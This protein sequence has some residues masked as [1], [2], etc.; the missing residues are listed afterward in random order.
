M[1]RK[2]K[3]KYENII[4]LINNKNYLK[5]T[6]KIYLKLE[7]I[8]NSKKQKDIIDKAELAGLLINI[9][10]EGLIKEVVEEGL[11]IIESN[12]D[13]FVK[14]ISKNS[15][16]YN[17]GNA[18]K[19]I[20]DISRRKKNFQF[21]L[22]NIKILVEAKNHY[23]KSLKLFESSKRDDNE[24]RLKLLTN[25]GST[26][27]INCRIS[28]SLY[29]FDQVLK[30][31]PIFPQANVNRSNEL[32]WLKTITGRY[33][34]QLMKQAYFGYLKAYNSS[35]TLQWRKKELQARLEGIKQFIKENGYNVEDINDDKHTLREFNQ[36][37]EY[38]QYCINNRLTLN[39]H[40][41]YCKC[42][43][44]RNDDLSIASNNIIVGGK[45]FLQ[46][47]RL[48][49]RIKSEFVFARHLYYKS[50]I[51]MENESLQVDN[52]VCYTEL[53]D[54]EYIGLNSEMIRTSFRLCFGILDKIAEGLCKFFEL[55]DEK[56]NI[57]FDNF[58]NPK[59]LNTEKLQER[60][61]KLNSI[62][63]FSLIALYSQATD[64]NSKIGEWKIYKDWRNA[65]EHNMFI[66]I[67]S[68]EIFAEK[69]PIKNIP[70]NLIISH[71]DFTEKTFSMLQFV[72]SAIFNFAFCIRK[73]SL[74]ENDTKGLIKT[75]YPKNYLDNE[76]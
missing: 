34:I 13:V 49:N 14:Y 50:T 72:R 16:E 3:K 33:S 76:N 40:A 25:L 69:K 7:K 56:E 23:W 4:E 53:S 65:L 55:S 54:N 51:K 52:E 30:I 60:W 68:N 32:I 59:N 21:N 19:A 15:L 27:S 22:E 70:D 38:R 8:N 71:N 44:S 26:L 6:K 9:G 1:E 41:L 47:E 75:L 73:E 39:E 64:L 10:D 58:W 42:I 43:A 67:N 24:F 28:E 29:Y 74:L 63:N 12:Y 62:D 35:K 37:S 48:L 66:I 57:Y 17:L 11:A 20:F 18:K 31:N 46:M 45:Y 61:N 5:A 2:A 36:L